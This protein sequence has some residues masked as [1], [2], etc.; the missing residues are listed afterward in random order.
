MKN[1]FYLELEEIRKEDD[2]E[3]IIFEFMEMSSYPDE[4][5][6]SI[7]KEISAYDFLHGFCIEFATLL[8]ETFGYEIECIRDN[9][10]N[11]VHAYCIIR[12]ENNHNIYIDVR[13]YTDE[14][15]LFMEEFLDWIECVEPIEYPLPKTGKLEMCK[16]IEV[17]EINEYAYKVAKNILEDYKEYYS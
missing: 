17:G 15:D 14:Y 12:N 8:H 4:D 1:G 3:D 6:N 9:E 13:G 16:N 7:H 10:N 5:P 11:L 2:C